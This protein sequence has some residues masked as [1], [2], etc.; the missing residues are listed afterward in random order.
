M[1]QPQLLSLGQ[2]FLLESVMLSLVDGAAGALLGIVSSL[3]MGRIAAWTLL[4]PPSVVALA[5][6][7]AGTIGAFFGF[8][9]ARKAARLDR[10]RRSA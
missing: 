2:Q 9:P 7:F 5:I 3:I 6:G 10:H 8:Y 4:I 1:L